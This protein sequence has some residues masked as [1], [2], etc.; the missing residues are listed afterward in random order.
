MSQTTNIGGVAPSFS[1]SDWVQGDAVEIE[2]LR[3]HVVLIEVFQ[4]NCPGCFLYSLPQAVDV[5]HRFH[6]Q[7]LDVIGIA[8]AFEDFSLNTLDNLKLMANEHVV[9]GETRRVLQQEGKLDDGKLPF[10]IPFPLAMDNI[11]SLPGETTHEEIAEFITQYIPE[12]SQ[13]TT[14]E[15]QQIEEKVKAY[16][17]ARFRFG[18]TF[19][20]YQLQ[21]TPSHLVIDKQGVLKAKEFGFFSDLEWVINSLLDD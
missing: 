6:E 19:K 4:V 11:I 10:H 13:R 9:M 12:F 5:Y 14:F 7:G 21:G 20:H 17:N 1:V 16:L 2:Q 3:G 8:T 18:E 15:Q